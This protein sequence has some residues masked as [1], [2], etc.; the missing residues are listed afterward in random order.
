VG[1]VLAALLFGTLEQA[2]LAINAR[3]P[4]DAMGMLE[5]VVIVV[6]ALADR[7]ARREASE[8]RLAPAERGAP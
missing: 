7:A 2:G 1:L 8:A 4:K 6:V 3:V 5:A